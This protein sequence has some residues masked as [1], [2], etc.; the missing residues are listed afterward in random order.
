MSLHWERHKRFYDLCDGDELIAT[1]ERTVRMG[2]P[3]YVWTVLANYGRPANGIENTL[4]E[5]KQ[6]VLRYTDNL[7][8][9]L[10]IE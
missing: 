9:Y 3:R 8:L 4:E 7:Q 10:P 5:A 6:Q 2:Q 1:V